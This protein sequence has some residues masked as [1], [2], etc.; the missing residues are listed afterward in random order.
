MIK[1][2]ERQVELLEEQNEL[3]RENSQLFGE[4]LDRLDTIA[5][6]ET[7]VNVQPGATNLTANHTSV[8]NVLA[9]RGR[10]PTPDATL[11]DEAITGVK[12]FD[13]SFSISHFEV[14]HFWPTGK[15]NPG[16]V[17]VSIKHPDE[18]SLRARVEKG[19]LCGKPIV[20]KEA[21]GD[22]FYSCEALTQRG[23]CPYRPA[24]YFDKLTFLC[25]LPPQK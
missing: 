11:L 14:D 21:N 22:K 10:A 23:S 13:G 19:C 9:E 7:Y 16:W 1:L 8:K 24:A 18:V 17:R 5:N 4:V 12:N 3:I 25:N 6:K 15:A 20:L 2:L